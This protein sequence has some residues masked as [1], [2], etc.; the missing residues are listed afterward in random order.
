MKSLEGETGY[1][2]KIFLAWISCFSNSWKSLQ[3]VWTNYHWQRW[4]VIYKTAG[5]SVE[6]TESDQMFWFFKDQEDELHKCVSKKDGV[7]DN[8]KCHEEIKQG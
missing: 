7:L 1:G 5:I 3:I 2:R 6:K 4:E 8:V